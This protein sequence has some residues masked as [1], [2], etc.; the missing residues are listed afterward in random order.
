M[1]ILFFGDVVGRPGRRIL[2][3]ALSEMRSQVDLVVVNGENAAHGY[4]ITPKIVEEILDM[5]V[6]V[7]TTGGHFYDRKEWK[8]VLEQYPQVLVPGNYPGRLDRGYYVSSHNVAIINIHGQVFVNIILE[9]PFEVIDRI[10]DI[11]QR[12]YGQIP[13]LVD[14]HGEATSEKMAM[15][16]YLAGRV[17]V[18]VGTHTHVQTADERIL[19]SKTGY[20]TDVG[21]CGC[22][23]TVIGM[24]KDAAIKRFTTGVPE[25]LEPPEKCDNLIA[26]GVLIEIDDDGKTTSMRRVVYNEK[27]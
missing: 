10:L 25:R 22:V 16:W 1:K 3:K 4:G 9:H 17:S 12:K 26:Q 27:F 19:A 23:D 21:M 11:V 7:I 18:V 8:D 14:F 20:I 2:K 5:G 13:I 15:G 24:D 6:D